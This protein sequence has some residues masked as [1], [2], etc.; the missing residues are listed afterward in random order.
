MEGLRKKAE[1]KLSGLELEKQRGIWKG[2]S[3]W[4]LGKSR[5]KADRLELVC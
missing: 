3:K 2:F 1:L 4:W 5:V